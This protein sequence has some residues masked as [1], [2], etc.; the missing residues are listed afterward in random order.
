MRIEQMVGLRIKALR[1]ERGMKQQ[2]LGNLLEP[3][4]GK[5]WHR[6]TV[7]LAEKGQRAYTAVELYALAEVL[8]TTVGHL[9]LP[10]IEVQQV[11][12]PSGEMRSH[13]ELCRLV[14]ADRGGDH[15]SVAME[16]IRKMLLWQH[17]ALASAEVMRDK[18][19]EAYLELTVGGS[20]AS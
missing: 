20:S 9:L 2:Q 19:Q 1:M 18:A 16:A 13:A 14:V 15:M 11:E 3:L 10:T 7:S 6:Q 8:E 4:L 17:E 5:A 12:M